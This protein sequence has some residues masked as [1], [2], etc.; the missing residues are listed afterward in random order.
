M[1]IL[2]YG[3]NGWIGNQFCQYLDNINAKYIRGKS[4]CNK[5]ED[6]LKEIMENDITHI[7]CFIGRTH[8]GNYTTIDYLEDNDK[9]Y[10]NVRDNLFSPLVLGLLSRDLGI[11]FS[12]LGTGCIFDGYNNYKEDDK[13]DFFG[14]NYS[15]V[16]GF[17]DELMH[18]FPNVLNLRIRMP[19]TDKEDKR[20]F[21][22]KILNYEKICSMDNSMTVL[23]DF[24][25]IFYKMMKN[26][27]TGTF[28]C[29]NPGVINHNEILD[30]Y[31]E[32]VDETFEYKNFTIEEQ[33]KVLK[34]KRSNNS[35][36]T[37]RLEDK[38]NILD[39]KTSV[40]NILKKYK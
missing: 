1:N 22:T 24:I 32:I 7:I 34:S 23:N 37:K 27:E 12:Y 10:E 16:K 18:L 19:I 29:V 35:L 26:N 8:G 31:K 33:D 4:R 25:P 20:N 11:H 38:Y 15:I 28:N 39:I 36:S 13:P 5:K 3:S 17:T 6:V 21:I 30:M 9:L 40:R 14:S 2:V